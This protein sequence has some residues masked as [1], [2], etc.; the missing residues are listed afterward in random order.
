MGQYKV[1][2]RCGCDEVRCSYKYNIGS[3]IELFLFEVD[4]WYVL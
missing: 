3:R 2:V 4:L 1:W